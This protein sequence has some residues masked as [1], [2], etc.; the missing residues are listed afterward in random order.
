MAGQNV[1]A[2]SLRPRQ[3]PA[4]PAC[5]SETNTTISLKEVPSDAFGLDADGSRERTIGGRKIGGAGRWPV[6]PI[7]GKNGGT[8]AV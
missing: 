1:P 3:R 2:G 8:W 4:S 7:A 6:G 5:G